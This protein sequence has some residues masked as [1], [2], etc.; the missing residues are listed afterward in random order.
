MHD[1][2]GQADIERSAN[3]LHNIKESTV[4]YM[5]IHHASPRGCKVADLFIVPADRAPITIENII[6]MSILMLTVAL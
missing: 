6:G 4:G 1:S 5:G 2:E 3:E